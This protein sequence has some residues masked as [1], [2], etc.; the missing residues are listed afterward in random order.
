VGE[1]LTDEEVRESARELLSEGLSARDTADRLAAETGRPRR[2]IYRLVVA[3]A[4]RERDT[5]TKSD[6][7]S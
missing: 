4:A 1:P 3:A 6:G 7:D 2:E 5:D